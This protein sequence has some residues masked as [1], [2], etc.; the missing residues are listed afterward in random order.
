M[1]TN[2]TDVIIVGAGLSGLSAAR[3]L[4]K[5]GKSFVVLEARDRVGD[6]TL[7]HHVG[8]GI[9]ELG[10]AW[11]NEYTQPRI[12]A[13]AKESGSDLVRQYV[14]GN[15]VFYAGGQRS[16]STGSMGSVGDP[17]AP[18]H[19]KMEALAER[20]EPKLLRQDPQPDAEIFDLDGQT[21]YTWY[22]AQGASEEDIVQFLEP[23]LNGLYGVGSTELSFLYHAL[24]VKADGECGHEHGRGEMQGEVKLMPR[25]WIRGHDR[26]KR[27]GCP[28][29]AHV[30]GKPAYEQVPRHS[31][32]R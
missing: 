13:L 20:I 5:A 21:I 31:L 32:P 17:L 30:E 23:A 2:T 9:V 26:N 10:A 27:E 3:K 19:A 28:V 15:N 7:T 4:H 22:R 14:D 1:S 8:D 29:P 12:C 16:L 18:L 6:K 11:V 24:G 25:R